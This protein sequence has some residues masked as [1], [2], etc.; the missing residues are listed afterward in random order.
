MK[1]KTIAIL[2]LATTISISGCGGCSKNEAST[3][4][5]E[6]VMETE[7]II[8]TEE[9]TETE[10][11]AVET[12]TTEPTEVSDELYPGFSSE[13]ITINS[14][15]TREYS[16]A[17]YN[18]CR[19]YNCFEGATDEQI[20]KMVDKYTSSEFKAEDYHNTFDMLDEID[21]TVYDYLNIP[22]PNKTKDSSESNTNSSST[23]NNS[24]TT[25]TNS[26]SSKGNTESNNTSGTPSQDTDTTKGYGDA[27]GNS[28]SEAP[29]QSVDDGFG[30]ESNT[31]MSQFFGQTDYGEW[32][33]DTGLIE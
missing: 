32:T 4:P 9:P 21:M 2:L 14:D 24:S 3:E 16:E 20:K 26:N 29:V 5:T 12:E 28:T 25:N 11:I 10:E 23:T 6:V 19:N 33:G 13:N 31:D 7:S 18:E 27:G 22:N 17:F 30:D 8:E 15:G 1:N